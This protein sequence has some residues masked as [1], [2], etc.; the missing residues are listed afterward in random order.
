MTPT[1]QDDKNS[2]RSKE[3]QTLEPMSD[4]L[5]SGIDKNA[6]QAQDVAS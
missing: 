2:P 4:V 5:N 3:Q 6:R 1:L